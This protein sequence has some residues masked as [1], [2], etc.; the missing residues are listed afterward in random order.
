MLI[1]EHLAAALLLM[2]MGEILSIDRVSQDNAS[3]DKH[4]SGLYLKNNKPHCVAFC[5]YQERDIPPPY[6]LVVA[7]HNINLN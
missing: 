4:R 1:G 6:L 3:C 7:L 5:L 2:S